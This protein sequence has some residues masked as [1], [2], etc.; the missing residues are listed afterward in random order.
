MLDNIT[1][2]TLIF[3]V[4]LL[5]PILLVFLLSRYYSVD[6]EKI[7][8]NYFAPAYL[9][10]VL[11]LIGLRPIG[12]QGFTD[13]LMYIEWFDKSQRLNIIQTKDIGFGLLIFITSKI[14]TIRLFF[15]V[16][17]LLSF[18][19]LYWVSKQVS[20]R[21]WFLFF[22]G[23]MVSL[24]FWNHQVFTL[25]QG[26]ASLVFLAALFH[27]KIFFRILLLVIAVSF[28]KSFLLPLFCYVMIIF[29]N[30]TYFYL[31]LWLVSIP[32]SY[33]FGN[34]IGKSISYLFPEDIRYYY[35]SKTAEEL[36]AMRFRWDVVLYSSIF[37]ILPYYFK[38]KDKKYVNIFN[39]Y[40]LT[41]IFTILIIWPAGD[42]IHR[43]A[44][45]SWFLSPVLVYYPLL[46]EKER[47]S[48]KPFLKF[49]T[50][51]Y[52]LILFYL[53]LKLYKQDFQFVN[54][55]VANKEVIR[56]SNFL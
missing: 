24:Y 2:Y 30:K 4:S 6:R 15:V 13:T 27:Q 39:L 5:L 33:Y 46:R 29:Y 42:F 28:H 21:Y 19:T 31:A 38:C 50:G 48:F 14:L 41:N 43:F 11:L 34:E 10:F 1:L 36:N 37:V 47:F 3:Y 51:F 49:V 23:T 26:I 25:R 18:I 35:V 17:I 7:L 32:V 8:F 56:I 54:R 22:L 55:Q 9:L 20:K 52:I 16:C 45:L 12:E 53:G 40:L 44:Y